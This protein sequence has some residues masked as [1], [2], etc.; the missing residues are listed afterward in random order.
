MPGF[1]N[2]YR[3]LSIRPQPQSPDLPAPGDED[4]AGMLSD[5]D[6]SDMQ[7]ADLQGQQAFNAKLP[8]SPITNEPRGVLSLKS[9][10]DTKQ[11]GLSALRRTMFPER[12]KAQSATNA[13]LIAGQS[14]QNIERQ[15]AGSAERVANINATA[16]ANNEAEQHVFQAGQG[17]LNRE[18]VGQRFSQGQANT[19]ARAAGTQA[20]QN[21]RQV[22]SQNEA[23]AKALE[24]QA[25]KIGALGNIF[26][27]KDKLLKQAADLRAQGRPAS[28]G[29]DPEVANAAQNFR[30][31]Y[32]NAGPD[33]ILGIL[34]SQPGISP[35]DMQALY[36]ELTGG[37]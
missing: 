10:Y 9:A 12:L 13:A 22:S 1:G 24:A 32:P 25:A 16:K 7:D 35:D 37:Q 15:K 21:G 11:Q 5:G 26:G 17:A 33:D 4:L 8:V 28:G 31:A 18:A 34:Q 6:V 36:D 3:T 20:G 30:R 19:N 14:A 2:L 27:A 29:G 23:R